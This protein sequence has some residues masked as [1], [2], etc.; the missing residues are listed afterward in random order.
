MNARS[1]DLRSSL[2]LGANLD[3]IWSVDPIQ[4][5]SVEKP[6]DHPAI[7]RALMPVINRAWAM[8]VPMPGHGGPFTLSTRTLKS[9]LDSARRLGIG[10]NI[11]TYLQ[12]VPEILEQSPD[13]AAKL[14]DGLSR[15]FEESPVPQIEWASM[16][17]IFG[18]DELE[19][20]L[21]SSRQSIARY[22]KGD[23]ATPPLIADRLHWL[24]MVVADLAGAYNALGIRRWFHRPRS[25][26]GGRSPQQVLGKAWAP[27]AALSRQIR[28]L[29]AALTELGAT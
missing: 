19:T 16:R 20:L 6:I 3:I 10:R 29:A 24:A 18:D 2:P 8:G 4:I 17:Q 7:L 15:A 27:D 1:A 23:R 12:A 11:G 14:L 21:G 13:E 22:A 9:L 28:A 26:L 25:A 5:S